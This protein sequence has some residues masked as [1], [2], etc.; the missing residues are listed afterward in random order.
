[1]LH[2]AGKKWKKLKEVVFALARSE[3]WEVDW[4]LPQGLGWALSCCST[5]SVRVWSLFWRSAGIVLSKFLRRR[6]HA[7]KARPAGG[8]AQCV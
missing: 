1:M 7:S 2:S 3:E 5:I 8:G 6:S 4:S